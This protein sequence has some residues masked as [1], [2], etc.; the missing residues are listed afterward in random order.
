MLGASKQASKQACLHQENKLLSVLQEPHYS[1][2]A[3]DYRRHFTQPLS[4]LSTDIY[5]RVG[6]IMLG[7]VMQLYSDLLIDTTARQGRCV[8]TQNVCFLKHITQVHSD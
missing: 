1:K 7:E 5:K 6:G 3:E 2:G 4:D 8:T